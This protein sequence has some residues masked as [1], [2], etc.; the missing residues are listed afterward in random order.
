MKGQPAANPTTAPAAARGAPGADRIDLM[1][2]FVR[3]VEA[4]SLSLAA[5]QLQ[6]TQPTISRRLQTLERQLG[7]RLLQ[8]STHAM[9]LTE[10]GARCYE[11]ARELVAD[12]AR[13]EAD[14]RGVGHAPSGTLRVVV[15]HAFGQE[16]LVGP[17][18]DYLRQ[19]PQVAVEW[20][21][22]DRTPDFIAEAIDCA[23]HVGEVHEPGL[24]AVRLADVPRAVIAAP[25]L[26]DGKPL[27]RRPQDLEGL[28]WLALRTFYRNEIV[29]RNL[30]TDASHGLSFAPRMST[31]SLYALHAAAR[32]GLGVAVGSS[33]IFADDIASG[34][35][36]HLLPQWQADPLPIYLVYPHA[37]F[38]PARLRLFAEA[39]RQAIPTAGMVERAPVPRERGAGRMPQARR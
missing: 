16:V 23:I 8:R 26:F 36:L 30:Q 39:M 18:A 6:T 14:L 28:P 37:R 34:R 27:P 2:T 7:V 12:W 10:D 21:L 32:L 35:L 9:K 15:P 25:S 20:L 31:D 33:W 17:L 13:F 4:G 11:R 24:V 5:A 22:H 3:I 1:Q 29:L 38:Y 19:Y